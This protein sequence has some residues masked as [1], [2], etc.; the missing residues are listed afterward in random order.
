MDKVI[1]DFREASWEEALDVVAAGFKEILE[2]TAV[3]PRP[4]SDWPK[5]QMRKLLFQNYQNRV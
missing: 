4:A 5:D 3:P 1:G 2:P